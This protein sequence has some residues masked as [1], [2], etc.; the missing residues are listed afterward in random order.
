MQSWQVVALGV[1]WDTQC[2]RN[3]PAMTVDQAALPHFCRAVIVAAGWWLDR[4]QPLQHLEKFFVMIGCRTDMAQ[5][6]I[7]CRRSWGVELH[8]A[9][10]ADLWIQHDLC[11]YQ[12]LV[13]DDDD[14]LPV[15][16]IDTETTPATKVRMDLVAVAVVAGIQ[17]VM[18]ADPD[19]GIAAGTSIDIEQGRVKDVTPSVGRWLPR[20]AG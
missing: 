12:G 11:L 20:S 15:A 9:G 18:G 10:R 6:H 8:A 5:R 2:A 1:V 7:G 16:D 19:A 17:R 4:K 14:G 13:T 3:V